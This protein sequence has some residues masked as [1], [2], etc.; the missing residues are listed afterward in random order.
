MNKIKIGI[1]EDKSFL[2]LSLAQNLQ[3]EENFDLV[4][5]AENG[6]DFVEK[7]MLLDE[8]H[9]PDVVL[10]DIDMPFLNGIE[11]TKQ[12][13]IKYPQVQV[14]ML[15]VFDDDEKI[16]EAV[17]AG[18]NG[19]LLKE[20]SYAK[21]KEAVR[22]VYNGGARMSAEIALKS[23]NFIRKHQKNVKS[24]TKKKYEFEEELTKRELEILVLISEGFTYQEISDKLFISLD[25]VRSHIKNI[26]QKLYVNNKIDAIIR[27]QK[28]GWL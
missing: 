8:I 19:Y 18:A 17:L 10:M 11:A 20:D 5:V 14:V 26:Y 22:E 3:A 4:I 15:T 24:S 28:K 9:L 16:F 25:T 2:R 7:I 1:A 27:A 12:V 6:Q 21:I 13:K 23:L